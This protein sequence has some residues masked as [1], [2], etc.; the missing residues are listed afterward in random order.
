MV[1]TDP[2][3]ARRAARATIVAGRSYSLARTVVVGWPCPDAQIPPFFNTPAH[4]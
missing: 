3:T 2:S 1:V 4:S